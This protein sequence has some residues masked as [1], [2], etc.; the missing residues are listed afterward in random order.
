MA[1]FE[2]FK[3]IERSLEPGDRS[4]AKRQGSGKGDI[5]KSIRFPPNLSLSSDVFGDGTA[6]IVSFTI[7]EYNGSGYNY[8]NASGT[9]REIIT[10]L[11]E[12]LYFIYLSTPSAQG[13]SY[14][15]KWNHVE[16]DTFVNGGVN[17][18]YN[19]MNNF[20]G[21]LAEDFETALQSGKD[22]AN[23]AAQNIFYQTAKKVLNQESV[24]GKNV[25]RMSGLVASPYEEFLYQNPT[26]REAFQFNF[27]LVPRNPS[28]LQVINDII[29]LFKWAS[30]PAMSGIKNALEDVNKIADKMGIDTKTQQGARVLSYPN[31]FGIRY[32]INKTDSG[33]D[34]S[35]RGEDNPW[36][37][38]IGPS[39]CSNVSVQYS[40]G[41]RNYVSYRSSKDYRFSS[42]DGGDSLD[43]EG[44]PI[45]YDLTLQFREMIFLTKE[46]INAGY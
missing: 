8:A 32:V 43:V 17:A 27:R 26:I 16:F 25:S 31:I 19:A 6:N 44:S 37:H 36:V 33:L 15:Q 29:H 10:K 12:P 42:E 23:A 24:L 35:N 41:A 20:K 28:E 18:V 11:G 39:C 38:K 5:P 30:H 21:S 1:S 14:S 7:Y 2:E 34:G 45:F 9:G 3:Q 22:I 46:T 4:V 40:P 13:T